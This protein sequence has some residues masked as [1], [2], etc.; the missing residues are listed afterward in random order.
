MIPP[1][2]F[3]YVVHGENKEEGWFVYLVL[4]LLFLQQVGK[5]F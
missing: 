2:S 1:S 5:D 4:L 3:I